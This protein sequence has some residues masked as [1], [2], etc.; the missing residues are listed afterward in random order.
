[1]PPKLISGA[2]NC[3][4]NFNFHGAPLLEKYKKVYEDA[5]NIYLKIKGPRPPNTVNKKMPSGTKASHNKLF[6]TTFDPC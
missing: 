3:Y 1:M 6:E 5:E 4:T 2:L